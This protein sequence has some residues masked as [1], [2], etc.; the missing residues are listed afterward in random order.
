MSED[1]IRRDT[2]EAIVRMIHQKWSLLPNEKVARDGMPLSS[3]LFDV[4]KSYQK[5]TTADGV[6]QCM[7]W[8]EEEYELNK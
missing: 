4:F 3:G 8:I 6:S 1:E 2:A 7:R 5:N